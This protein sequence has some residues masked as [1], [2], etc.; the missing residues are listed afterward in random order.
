MNDNL[1]AR[2]HIDNRSFI[3]AKG[4]GKEYIDGRLNILYANV[5][6]PFF[7]LF[8]HLLFPVYYYFVIISSDGTSKD[9]VESKRRVIVKKEK[10]LHSLLATSS[11]LKNLSTLSN[12]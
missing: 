7:F 9:I 12:D 10:N 3:S 4:K 5:F 2:A 11:S 1:C 6:L 8:F